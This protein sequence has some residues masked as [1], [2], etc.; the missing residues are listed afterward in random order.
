MTPSLSH[1]GISAETR[2][3]EWN[4]AVRPYSVGI[5]EEVMLLEPRRRWALAQRIDDVLQTLPA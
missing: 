5:E 3:A 2:W 4:S 1:S